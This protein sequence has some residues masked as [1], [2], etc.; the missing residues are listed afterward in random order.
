MSRVPYAGDTQRVVCNNCEDVINEWAELS[1][2][3]VV[4]G[5]AITITLCVPCLDIMS[6]VLDIDLEHNA[7]GLFRLSEYG[8]IEPLT[9]DNN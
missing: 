5:N 1:I 8:K 6:L 3:N 4:R 7:E 2:T 9:R